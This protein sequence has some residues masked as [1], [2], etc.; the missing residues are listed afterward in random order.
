MGAEGL[1]GPWEGKPWRRQVWGGV[2]MALHKCTCLRSALDRAGSDRHWLPQTV[3][4]GGR[5]TDW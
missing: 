5:T 4:E 3:S 2:E 1:Q